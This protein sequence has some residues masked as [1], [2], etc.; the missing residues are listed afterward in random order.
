MPTRTI[1]YIDGLNLYYGALRNTPYRWLD[2]STYFQRL[3]QHDEVI[4]IN[5]FTARVG[6]SARQRQQKYLMALETTPDVNVVLG[7]FKPK[8]RV[9][10][11]PD[12]CHGGTR[13]FMEPEE[14]RT[15]V[16]IAVEM[17]DDALNDHCDTLVLVTGDSDLVPPVLK[18]KSLCPTKQIIVYVPSRNPKRGAAVELRGVADKDRDLPLKLI[19]RCQFPA[20]IPYENSTIDKPPEW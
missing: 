19:E 18:I 8:S 6:G 4:R 14:K 9:C 10:R 12:C 20:S 15:D 13:F 17:M 11:V 2:I 5:Y 1:V 16:S 3:R 7:R